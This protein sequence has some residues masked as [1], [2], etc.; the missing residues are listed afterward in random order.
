MLEWLAANQSLLPLR[1]IREL[2]ISAEVKK[3]D[4]QNRM[5][6]WLAANQ[7]LLPLRGSGLFYFSALSSKLERFKIKKPSCCA[8]RAFLRSRADLNRCTRFCR[9]LPNRSA[10]GP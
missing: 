8:R 7:S 6:E 9:P 1:G 4:L 10:T 5:L 3:T 2:F